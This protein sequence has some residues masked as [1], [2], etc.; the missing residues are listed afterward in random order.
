[1]KFLLRILL[2][3]LG[4]TVKT[5]VLH[6]LK[7]RTLKVYLQVIQG[8]RRTMLYAFIV[9]MTLQLMVFSLIGA[10][11]CGVLLIDC[12]LQCKLQ[13][14]LGSFLALLI[15][16]AIGFVFLMSEKTWFRVSGAQSL[17]ED[18]KRN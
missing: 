14:L 8:G 16:P 1:M 11:V 18:L 4:Q 13:I 5:R 6:E 9:L 3:I 15:L 7:A 17:I 10:V 2:M 12:D